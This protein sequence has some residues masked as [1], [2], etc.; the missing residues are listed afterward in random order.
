MELVVVV[1]VSPNIIATLRIHSYCI[2]SFLSFTTYAQFRS[3]NFR[4]T[5]NTSSGLNYK[6]IGTFQ[7]YRITNVSDL[8]YRSDTLVIQ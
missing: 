4:S 2:V 5:D 6:Q 3:T 1:L 7:I 8:N